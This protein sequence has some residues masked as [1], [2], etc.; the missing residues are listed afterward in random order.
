MSG[1]SL[2]GIDVAIVEIQ[3]RRV[4]TIGFTETAYPRAVREGSAENYLQVRASRADR[5]PRAD[6]LPRGALEHDADRRAI[7]AGRAHRGAGGLQLPGEGHR[8]GRT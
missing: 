7:R 8:G 5:V 3:G 1:T 6:D 4:E 2:D